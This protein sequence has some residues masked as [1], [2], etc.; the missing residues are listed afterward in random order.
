MLARRW[1]KKLYCQRSYFSPNGSCN[2][3]VNFKQRVVEPRDEVKGIIARIYFY[4]HDRYDLCS[5]QF[6]FTTT[7]GCLATQESKKRTTV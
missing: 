3:K 5:G 7:H 6:H 1:P 2:F 4:M